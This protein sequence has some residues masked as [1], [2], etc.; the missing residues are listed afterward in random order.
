LQ[1]IPIENQ[2]ISL[3]EVRNSK[4]EQVVVT[5]YSLDVWLAQQFGI[6][7]DKQIDHNN[8][9]YRFIERNKKALPKIEA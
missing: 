3:N 8:D 9:F 1:D 7:L 2:R 4:K 6:D 5:D